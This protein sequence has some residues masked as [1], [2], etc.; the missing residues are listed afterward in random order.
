MSTRE[1]ALS[2]DRPQ[3]PVLIENPLNETIMLSVVG[4]VQAFSTASAEYVLEPYQ[5]P[6][7]TFSSLDNEMAAQ[8]HCHTR[9]TLPP[10]A[11]RTSQ[12]LRAS[13]SAFVASHCTTC[14]LLCTFAH[15]DG[16]RRTGAADQYHFPRVIARPS[17]VC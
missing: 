10:V 4:A 17:R 6:S 3:V 11:V 2:T 16:C 14:A 13:A 9:Y 8:S 15:I 7:Y 5:V 1:Y 12:A